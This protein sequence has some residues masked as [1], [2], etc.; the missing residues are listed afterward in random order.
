M[1]AF[2]FSDS[3]RGI[4]DAIGNIGKNLERRRRE[5]RYAEVGSDVEA[6]NLRGASS[7]LLALGD[8][9]GAATLLQLNQKADERR[10]GQDAITGL[11]NA[12]SGAGGG[13]FSYDP[14]STS[15]A[16]SALPA[17]LVRSESGGN[18]AAQNDAVGAGGAVGH[19]GRGQFSVAR[20]QDAANAGAIPQGTTPQ[21]FMQSPQLQ[22]AAEAWHV[23]DINQTIKANGY[24]R[25]IGQTING[26]PVTADG[27]IAVAHLGGKGGLQRFIETGGAYNPADR[28]GTRLSDYLAMGARSGG[29]RSASA[30]MPA[31][32]ARNAS[33]DTGGRGFAVLG[34]PGMSGATFN[35]ITATDRPLDPKFQAEGVSQPWM[36]SALNAL[37]QRPVAM[38]SAATLPPRR[39]YDL[40]ADLPAPGAAQA[41]GNGGLAALG[42]NTADPT[43]D[44]AGALSGLVA[45]EEAR[46]GQRSGAS[47]TSFL[48]NFR[49]QPA[50]VVNVNTRSDRGL[51]N[52]DVPGAVVGQ[53]AP[54]QNRADVPAAGAAPTIGTMPAAGAGAASQ[55]AGS[56]AQTGPTLSADMPRPTNA[57]EAN[58]Y[59]W[60]K[61]IESQKGRVAA[62]SQ[63]LTNPNLPAN[64]RAVGE[65][66][67]KDALEQS[68]APDSVKEFMYARGMGWTTAKN[69]AEYAKEKQSAPTDVQEYEYAQRKGFAGSYLDFQ[70]E[71]AAAKNTKTTASDKVDE[72]TAAADKQG[73]QGEERKFFIANGRLPTAGEKMTEGQANAALYADR[74]KAANEVL[75]RPDIAA[76]GTGIIDRGLSMVPVVGNYGTS[77]KFQMADQAQRDF[78]NAVLRRE[79]GAAISASEFDHAR[80]QYFPQPGDGKEVLAQKARN[81]QIAIDGISNAAGPTYAKR[82]QQA[83]QV[84]AEAGAP[85]QALTASSQ[86]RAPQPLYPP[87]PAQA[88]VRVQS[89]QE[90]L[91]LPSGTP[92]IL[93]DGRIGE[94]P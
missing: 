76:A 94:V 69:P 47:V 65:I 3:F 31:P 42:Q 34:Q 63:A 50:P 7:K 32:G 2:D 20:I 81:R 10:L 61:Q 56:A 78:I 15:G 82:Q 55:P 90:A 54:T 40:Q 52:G 21:Q 88:P 19:F 75:S 38:A 91:K 92:I 70:K 4:N 35:A 85:P 62:L 87:Q 23:G 46:R 26:I 66:F 89:P 80:K 28:N 68:K 58:D 74:M 45:S 6:G 25:L 86:G 24:D 5:E 17:S 48:D 79:S 64:A 72:N 57:Q 9:G 41:M 11:N 83:G 37:G 53:N 1:A 59:R 51:A 67:L 93:P 36:G 29:M 73:L 14:A 27:L 43:R 12:I 44:N 8:I 84:P 22:Q 77:D 49:S 30:D 60:T 13:S 18:F 71:K 33:L 16:P 39:P